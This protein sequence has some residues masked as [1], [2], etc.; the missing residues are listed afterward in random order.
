MVIKEAGPFGLLAVPMA[1]VVG[2]FVL[3]CGIFWLLN[4]RAPAG[5]PVIGLGAMLFL[6]LFAVQWGMVRV[7][8]A[9]A[10]ASVET[11]QTLVASGISAEIN[12]QIMVGVLIVAPYLLLCLIAAMAGVVRGPRNPIRAVPILVLVILTCLATFAAGVFTESWMLGGGRAALYLV[13]G[14]MLAIAA[15]GR[16]NSGPIAACSAACG[17]PL[18]VVAV[19]CATRSMQLREAF[20]ALA[21][22]GAETKQA[23]LQDSLAIIDAGRGFSWLAIAMAAIVALVSVM[24]VVGQKKGEGGESLG[25]V[26]SVGVMVALA[27]MMLIPLLLGFDV[28]HSL[29]LLG[30]MFQ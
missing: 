18:L 2:F 23:M 12:S 1:G 28:V 11:R 21:M 22:T 9:A 5:I 4:W 10:Q 30:G 27:P 26:H 15:V 6:E 20:V 24:L 19:E 17:Y 8:W 7:L 25:L 3:V 29:E 14:L 16:S 13:T